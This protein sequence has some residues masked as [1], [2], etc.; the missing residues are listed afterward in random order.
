MSDTNETIPTIPDYDAQ[1]EQIVKWIKFLFICQIADLFLT[2][3]APVA[4]LGNITP[5]I[6][7]MISVATIVAFFKLAPVNGRYRKAAIFYSISV[8]GGIVVLLMS[9]NTAVL[10][11]VVSV[12]SAIA[13]YQELNAHSEITAH[14]DAKL[15][16]RWHSLFFIELFGGFLAAG[17]GMV[18]ILV[19]LLA[20]ADSGADATV[21]A[22]CSAA[23]SVILE[24]LR[25]VYLKKTLDLYKQ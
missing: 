23:I 24:I 6:T 19:F 20:G 4:I 9:E 2:F 3:L 17:L 7:R 25:I 10:F 21:E 14:K 12:C 22:I 15:S 18:A 1:R 11:I 13:S 16:K 8:G 5:W